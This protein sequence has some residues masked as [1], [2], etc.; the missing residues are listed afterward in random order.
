KTTLAVQW[1]HRMA[2][3]FPDGQLY[4]NLRGYDPEQPVSSADALA[5][6]LRA[7][8]VAGQDIALDQ[9][10][11]AAQYRSALAGR[12]VLVVLDNAGSVDQVRPLLPG[13]AT[14]LTVVTSCDSLAGLVALD[15]AHRLILDL[16]PARDAIALLRR[17]IGARVAA[18][19]VAAA[20]LAEQCA[21][22]P[23]ALRVAAE[24]AAIHPDTSLARL[25]D[26]LADQRHRLDLLDSAGD[27]RTA[28]RSV[29][30]WSYHGLPEPAARTFRLLGCHPGPGFDTYAVAAL[31]DTPVQQARRLCTLLA[32]AHLVQAD[33]PGRYTSH[34]LLRAYATDLAET[35]DGPSARRAARGRLFDYYLAAAA[36]AMDVLHPAEVHKRPRVAPAGTP[37]PPLSDADTARRWLDAERSNLV[38]VCVHAAT[39]GWP[40]HTVQLSQ[41]VFRYL[42]LC[43]HHTEALTIHTHARQAAQQDG[44]RPGEAR[45]L[46]N[47]AAVYWWRAQ[48]RQAAGYYEQAADIFHDSGDRGGEADARTNLGFVHRILG[49]L[50]RSVRNNL[51][52]LTLHRETDNAIGQARTL[53]HLGVIDM[54]LGQLSRAAGYH[55]QAL[56]LCRANGYT[57]VEAD[58]LD[59]LGQVHQRQGDLALAAAEHERA[60]ALYRH[61]GSRAGEASALTNL[62]TVLRLRGALAP[63]IEYHE[64]ALALQRQGG[65]RVREATA[66]NGLAAALQAAGRPDASRRYH[67]DAL[68]VATEIGDPYEQAHAHDGLAAA[69]HAEGDT[70]QARAHWQQALAIHTQL[71][72]HEADRVRAA[73]RQLDEGPGGAARA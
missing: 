54:M 64:Q 18:E 16:L 46:N 39:H 65:T 36:A 30:S 7:F 15:G 12:R 56:T 34:D 3:R 20:E 47:L 43:G 25:V 49:E 50:T 13:T 73:L 10:E 31:A 61:N 45:A 26:E 21:R 48:F 67:T 38:A 22:L 59:N 5:R 71:G 69:H 14:C 63:A 41:T 4:V 40:R 42:D 8:G 19:P 33:G 23:L 52:A 72:T 24:L 9:D 60:L 55:E 6:F 29:F 70:G 57:N 58:A 44:D 35:E 66:L 62:G 51:R 68:A 17:L 11:R 32:R 28:T 1:A 2:D 27:V 37:V 53:T